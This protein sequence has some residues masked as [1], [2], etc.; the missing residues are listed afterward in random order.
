ME[1]QKRGGEARVTFEQMRVLLMIAGAEDPFEMARLLHRHWTYTLGL[2]HAAQ[3][4]LRL[5]DG[6]P[7]VYL[8]PDLFV[9][10]AEDILFVIDE[11][12]AAQVRR[13]A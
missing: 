12:V 6:R 11:W 10:R 2:A 5:D 9:Q 3:L 7:E 13:V 8:D 1:T 4:G